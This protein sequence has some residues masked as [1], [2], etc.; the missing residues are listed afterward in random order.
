MLTV[1]RMPILWHIMKYYS[2]YGHTE[3]VLCLGYKGNIIR[4]F[5][6]NYRTWTTDLTVQ[7]GVDSGITYHSQEPEENW[8]VTLVDTGLETQTGGRVAQA[9]K[10]VPAHEN[11]LLTYG[12]GVTDLPLD[13]LVVSHQKS[14]TIV[15]V[16]GVMPPG[17]FGEIQCE[18]DGTVI[19]FN[20]KP[21]V[22]GALISGGY[23]VCSPQ[24]REYLSGDSNEVFEQEPMTKLVRDREIAV[25]RH[26]GFWQC[27]DTPRDWTYLN[28]LVEIGS[29]PWIR[30]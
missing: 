22:S 27:M 19:G 21:Q 20:E 24:I 9:L 14:G 29:A 23:F 3:F 17:R 11:F 28:H 10:Y 26:D 25:H 4:D 13:E 7:L 5:F 18:A 30:W 15:T 16:T 2:S 6:L 8:S 1:G 12:D